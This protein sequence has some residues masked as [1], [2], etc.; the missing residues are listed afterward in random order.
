MGWKTI[1]GRR[2]Y[3]RV[4]RRGSRITTTY[5]GPGESGRL[6]A[7]IQA[8]RNKFRS[9]ERRERRAAREQVK[10]EEHAFETWFN[11][12]QAVADAVMAEAGFHKHKRQWRRKRK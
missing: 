10:A 3:Y 1:N 2:Y 7:E 5:H 8:I 11:Q 12:V 9:E 4:K 6:M